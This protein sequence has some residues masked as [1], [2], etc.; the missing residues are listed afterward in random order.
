MTILQAILRTL[1]SRALFTKKLLANLRQQ[2]TF[3]LAR[4][5]E[6]QQR[7]QC[8]SRP[9]YIYRALQARVSAPVVTRSAASGHR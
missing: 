9:G 6:H 2:S 8:C 3:C 5:K 1:R 4:E 7:K